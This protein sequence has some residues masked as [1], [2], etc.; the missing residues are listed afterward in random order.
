MENSIVVSVQ[1][2]GFYSKLLIEDAED[3]RILDLIIAK[4]KKAVSPYPEPQS[5]GEQPLDKE[6]E[7]NKIR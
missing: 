2:K 6:T 7:R 3:L 5:L 4:V 1:G